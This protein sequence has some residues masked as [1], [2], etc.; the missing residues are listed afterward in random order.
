MDALVRLDLKCT[1]SPLKA[2]FLQACLL[3]AP[4]AG[5]SSLL[6]CLVGKNVSAVS[7]KVNTTDEATRG[8]FT[9]VA[10]KTQMAFIDTPG[11]TK[12]SNTMRSKLLVTRAWESIEESDQVIFVVDAAKRLSYEV[13]EALIRLKKTAS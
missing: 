2:K 3:G 11:V 7:N 8:I 4:N 10:R 9:D 1:E 13:K 6:N 12:A 5:K